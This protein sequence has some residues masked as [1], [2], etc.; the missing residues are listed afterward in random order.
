MLESEMEEEICE[1]V[2]NG[3][4]MGEVQGAPQEEKLLKISLSIILGTLAP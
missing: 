3:P 4:D 2:S 1:E